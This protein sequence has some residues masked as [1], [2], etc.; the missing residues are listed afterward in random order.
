[1]AQLDLFSGFFD[2]YCTLLH[3]QYVVH[4]VCELAPGS[5]PSPVFQFDHL[6]YQGINQVT[7]AAVITLPFWRRDMYS[8]I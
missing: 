8:G 7:V 1:M 5:R 6:D 2:Q 4:A 3:G